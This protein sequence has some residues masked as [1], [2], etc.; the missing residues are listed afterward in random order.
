VGEVG[1]SWDAE[2]VLW[3]ASVWDLLK[4][5]DC[6]GSDDSGGWDGDRIAAIDCREGILT[7][8]GPAGTTGLNLVEV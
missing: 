3:K 8:F 7:V 4:P 5:G 1:R 6:G 2:S